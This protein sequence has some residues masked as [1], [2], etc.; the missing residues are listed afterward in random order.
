MKKEEKR[1]NVFWV[2]GGGSLQIPLIEEVRRV[3]PS[4][5]ILVTD[6]SPDCLCKDLGDYFYP[7]DIFDLEEN[8]KLFLDLQNQ[9]MEFKGILAAGLDANFTMAVLNKL[10]G[11]PA[12]SPLAAYIT[13]HKH[14]FR[15]FL[16]KHNLPCPRWREAHNEK[17][18]EEAVKFVGF[19]LIIKNIDNSGSRGT[20]K[21][22]TKPSSVDL[23]NAFNTA[24]AASSTKSAVIEELFVGPEQT[25]EGIFD[26]KGKFWRCLITDREFDTKSVW[27]TELSLEHP[28]TLSPETQDKLYAL[29]EKTARL[30]GITVGTAKADTMVTKRGPVIIEMTTRLSGGFDSQYLVP[31]A[32]G[33]NVLRVAI[34]TALGKPFPGS[35]LEDHKNG[36]A[37][38]DSLW[39]TPGE[40][41]I[42]IEG[43]E[44]AKKMP[45]FVLF[46]I[47][48]GVGDI[49]EV[50]IDST[51][52]ICFAIVS[53]K[54]RK[55]A[56]ENLKRILNTIVIKTKPV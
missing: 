36:V 1:T 14:V 9:G 40:K 28:T 26:V 27:A 5:K 3:D 10:A 51:K 52:R 20:R 38:L 49:V 42:A 2:I 7:V 55:E 43:V 17:E 45:G 47:R 33:K 34:L 22:F 31:A 54:D 56:K 18:L 25:T 6:R 8:I 32:T 53:G 44:K 39:P 15:A 11:L 23:T 4:L 41:I 48:Y 35:L 21:F 29:V 37:L 24:A 19:P 13:H 50:P 30:L 12:V 16:E 46:S